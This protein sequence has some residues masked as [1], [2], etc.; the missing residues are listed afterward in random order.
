MQILTTR[1]GLGQ[2][3]CVSTQLPGSSLHL[4][5]QESDIRDVLRNDRRLEYEY[6]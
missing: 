2:R 3:F 1:S 4:E 6:R 5:Q